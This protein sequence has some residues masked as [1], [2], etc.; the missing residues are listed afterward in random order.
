MTRLEYT[1]GN[2]GFSQVMGPEASYYTSVCEL[3]TKRASQL[4]EWVSPRG[5]FANGCLLC[6]DCYTSQA[7]RS[8]VLAGVHDDSTEPWD[9]FWTGAYLVGVLS[10]L[11][12]IVWAIWLLVS[13]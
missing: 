4:Y 9:A 7:Y 8:R 11:A 10:V 3:C 12:V 2:E 1:I 6:K 13:G 5:S